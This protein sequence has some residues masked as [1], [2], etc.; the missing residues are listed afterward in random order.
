MSDPRILRIQAIS[1]KAESNTNG[2]LTDFIFSLSSENLLS[3][4]LPEIVRGNFLS[5]LFGRE[6]LSSQISSTG[7]EPDELKS[8]SNFESCAERVLKDEPA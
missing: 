4:D 2:V 1:S 7:F 6:G 5:S 8:S 3:Q